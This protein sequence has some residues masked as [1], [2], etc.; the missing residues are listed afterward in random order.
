M[1]VEGYYSGQI[2]RQ[3]NFLEDGSIDTLTIRPPMEFG[4]VYYLGSGVLKV[5][6]PRN[7][8][9]LNALIHQAFANSFINNPTALA[10]LSQTRT[11]ILEEFKFRRQFPAIPQSGLQSAKLVHVCF[12]ESLGDPCRYTI[13]NKHADI[14]ERLQSF[15]IDIEKI[16]ILKVGIQF[17]MVPGYGKR[18]KIITLTPNKVQNLNNSQLDDVLLEHL[19]SWGILNV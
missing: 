5:K 12:R 4:M 3:D 13:E 18:S 16:E 10:E 6:T 7:D 17:Q 8:Y 11:I 2:K 19:K 1:I 14:L 9:E 15:Q